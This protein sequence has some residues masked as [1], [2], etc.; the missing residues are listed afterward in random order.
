MLKLL[1]VL[2]LLHLLLAR[3]RSGRSTC[4]QSDGLVALLLR[5]RRKSKNAT[6]KFFL[7]S[8]GFL[9]ERHEVRE[10]PPTN[11]SVR[12]RGRSSHTLLQYIAFGP[13]I[14]KVGQEARAHRA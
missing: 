1:Q 4:K 5:V 11:T 12:G 10:G 14:A 8:G 9:G 6:D 2:L 7:G 3:V 13:H